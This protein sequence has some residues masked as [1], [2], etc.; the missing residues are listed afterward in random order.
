MLIPC[1]QTA[2]WYISPVQQGSLNSLL[3]LLGIS[4][5][6]FVMAQYKLTRWAL[7]PGMYR[8]FTLRATLNLPDPWPPVAPMFV[9]NLSLT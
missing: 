3:D 6:S 9:W 4:R 7:N 2:L 1:R 8:G 5:E